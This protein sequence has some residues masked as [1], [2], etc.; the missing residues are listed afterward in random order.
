MS[1][2]DLSPP[3]RSPDN[4]SNLIGSSRSLGG[5]H[6]IDRSTS[7]HLADITTSQSAYASP[8]SEATIPADTSSTIYSYLSKPQT[9]IGSFHLSRPLTCCL[10]LENT[11]SKKV[12]SPRRHH[13]LVRCHRSRRPLPSI[14][15]HPEALIAFNVQKHDRDNQNKKRRE[16]R[17]KK[18]REIDN[19]GREGVNCWT[20]L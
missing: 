9:P 16:R 6:F 13:R 11:R 1:S 19:R 17:R 14:R 20:P 7:F 8:V 3:N 18:E 5:F 2:F 15:H 4:R 10:N 12:F